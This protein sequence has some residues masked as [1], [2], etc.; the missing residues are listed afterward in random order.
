VAAPGLLTAYDAANTRCCSVYSPG[1]IAAAVSSVVAN[2]ASGIV[3]GAQ[4]GTDAIGTVEQSWTLTFTSATAFNITGDTLG[5]VGS[6]NVGSTTSPNNGQ[7]SK[8][9]FTLPPAVFSGTFASGD[10]V[11]FTTSPAAVPIWFRRNV[12]ANTPSLSGNRFVVGC[13]GESA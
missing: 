1:N 13:D 9:Y 7:F 11:T 4:I 6:G 2:S 5:S 3:D 10:T 8:P 12:P